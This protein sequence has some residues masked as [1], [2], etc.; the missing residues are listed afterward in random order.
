MIQL[1]RRLNRRRLFSRRERHRNAMAAQAEQ[2]LSEVEKQ[3]VKN[4]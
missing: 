4:P 2:N 3:Q 1:L